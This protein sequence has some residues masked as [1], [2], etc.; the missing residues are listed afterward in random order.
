MLQDCGA[1]TVGEHSCVGE[2][3]TDAADPQ[4]LSNGS[5]TFGRYTQLVVPVCV[6]CV[7]VC[8]CMPSAAEM[9]VMLLM[10]NRCGSRQERP[11]SC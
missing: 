7:C 3:S 1:F 2:G 8:L 4:L 5:F 11:S 10:L 9:Q 6:V